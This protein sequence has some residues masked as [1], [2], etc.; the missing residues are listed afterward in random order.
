MLFKLVKSILRISFLLGIC[1][2]A[3]W[4]LIARPT[5]V[6]TESNGDELPIDVAD[7][8]KHVLVLSEEY[9]PRSS[10][11]PKN[12]ISISQYIESE[13]KEAAR[14][15]VYQSY[16]V[17]GH[18]YRNVIALFGPETD[19]VII[20][21]AHYDAFHEF[22]GADDNASGVAGLIELGKLLSRIELKHQVLLIAYTLEEPPYFASTHMGS[23]V[24]AES[25]EN[26]NVRIMISLEMIGYFDEESYSQSFPLS[27][28]SLFYPDR[29][30]YIAVVDE[31]FAN[32]AMGLK[33]AINKYSALS[34]YSINAPSSIIGIDFSDHR[35]YWSLGY[36]AVMVTDTSFYRNQAYHTQYDTAD[37]LDYESMA[38]VIVGVFRYIQ[39]LAGIDDA[40]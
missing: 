14:E 33:S 36:P 29:G 38:N 19:D 32:N 26:K 37:R 9:F 15:V 25:L 35:S 17:H 22:P 21:G 39:D 18:E 30:D 16:E 3:I 40:S 8:K 10:D 2:F 31:L 1:L 24:H 28:M 27:L 5:F 13:L 7:L 11:Y 34:A 4:V 6:I 23:F 20:V 12:L